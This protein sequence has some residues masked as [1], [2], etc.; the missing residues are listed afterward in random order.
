MNSNKNPIAEEKTLRHIAFIMDGN[1]RWA[2]KRGMPR[3]FGHKYGAR[4]FRDVVKYCGEIGIEH[5]TVYAFSTENWA[6]P[7]NEIDS[8][9]SLLEEYIDECEKNMSEYDVRLRFIGDVTVFSDDLQAK[10]S[11]IQDKTKDKRFGLDVALNYGGRDELVHAFNKLIS[12]GK[13]SVTEQDIEDALYTAGAPAP[14]LII[15]TAGEKR[16]SNFL[17][18]Q[19]AYSEFYFT[20]VLW[21]DIT[22]R[23]IDRAIEDFYKRKRRYG[24]V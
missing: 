23:E 6:R 10:I 7:Q 8:I 3:R 16:L 4:A 15:R 19:S 17:M 21:P 14:D 2:Q 24:K 5:I 1:G 22:P 13:A 18:W 11:D 9:M 12:E 20:D